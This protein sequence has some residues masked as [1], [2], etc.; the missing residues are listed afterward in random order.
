MISAT[1]PFHIFSPAVCNHDSGD[2][3]D[4]IRERGDAVVNNISSQGNIFLKALS[5]STRSDVND[6]M[7]KHHGSCFEKTVDCFYGCIP[8]HCRNQKKLPPRDLRKLQRMNSSNFIQKTFNINKM[9][10]ILV[11]CE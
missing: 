3:G 8:L 10:I 1:L 9:C 2:S 5:T 4:V 7:M 6:A 11:T